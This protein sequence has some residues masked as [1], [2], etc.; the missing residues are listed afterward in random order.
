MWTP[1]IRWL[2]SVQFKDIQ[3]EALFRQNWWTTLKIRTIGRRLFSTWFIF[4]AGSSITW[5]LWWTRYSLLLKKKN[6]GRQCT[7][8]KRRPM[9]WFYQIMCQQIWSTESLLWKENKFYMREQQL[10]GRQ[11]FSQAGGPLKKLWKNWKKYAVTEI[12]LDSEDR[13]GDEQCEINSLKQV[14][15]TED[16]KF[17]TLTSTTLSQPLLRLT[18]SASEMRLLYHCVHRR[19]KQKPFWGKLVTQMKKVCS[20]AHS[21][22]Q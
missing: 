1:R 18:T 16:S 12:R 3:V 20:N 19:A 9:Q 2:A 14:T 6:G 15:N 7:S 10:Y 13:T 4:H 8:D 21:L 11:W 5:I 22:F 17:W